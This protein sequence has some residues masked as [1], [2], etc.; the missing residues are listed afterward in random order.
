MRSPGNWKSYE[1]LDHGDG[2][3]LERFGNVV[4]IRPET[5]AWWRP[6]Q[7]M[8][9]WEKSAD[10]RFIPTGKQKGK[11]EWKNAPKK[12]TLD[13]QLGRES[14]KFLLK[15]TQFKHVG[16]FPEQAVNWEY[17]Y[18]QCKR[19][20]SP[21]VLNLFAYTGGASL[22]A[23]AAG[24]DVVHV[25]SIRQVVQWSSENMNASGLEGIRWV[26]EDALKFAKKEAKRGKKYHGVILD[27]PAFGYGKQGERWKLEKGLPELLD[28]VQQLLEPKNHFVVFNAYAG[29]LSPVGVQNFL[30]EHFTNSRQQQAHEMCLKDSYGKLLPLGVVGYASS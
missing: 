11:W 29:G 27:P 10:G 17:I 13:Y 14:L 8:D 9:D 26:V 7:S 15:P 4:L 19:I 20:R 2:Q 21:K 1:L 16:I 22:A 30:Q 12:W 3:K 24:A 18:E 23:K 25:D 6:T 5:A 28:V